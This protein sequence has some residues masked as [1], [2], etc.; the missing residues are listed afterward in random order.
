M[1]NA[2]LEDILIQAETVISA[3][4]ELNITVKNLHFNF[5]AR[6]DVV[7]NVDLVRSWND[8]EL[9]LSSLAQRKNISANAAI[10]VSTIFPRKIGFEYIENLLKSKIT[11]I[12][13][14]YY[15]KKDSFRRRWLPNSQS[16][17]E[18]CIFLKKFH[19]ASGK[20]P[21]FH[22]CFINGQNDSTEDLDDLIDVASDFSPFFDVNIVRFNPP[23]GSNYTESPEERV[24]ENVEYL[25]K[26]LPNSNVKIISRVGYDVKASCGMFLEDVNV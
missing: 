8:V 14:S 26:Y 12:Y 2:V 22:F 18:S 6:G 11:N 7:S 13:Y 5:M 20:R 17:E 25:R 21:R 16:V 10:L 1:T 19:E 4:Q 15:S 9:G 24:L 3:L 23:P